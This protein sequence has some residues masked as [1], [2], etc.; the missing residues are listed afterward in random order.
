MSKYPVVYSSVDHIVS[1][2]YI[3]CQVIPCRICCVG[4]DP[5]YVLE[6]SHQRL[7]ICAELVVGLAGTRFN[8]MPFAVCKGKDKLDLDVLEREIHT[9][10]RLHRLKKSPLKNFALIT[11]QGIALVVNSSLLDGACMIVLTR[12]NMT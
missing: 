1:Q 4:V 5:P 11:L 7:K 6:G 8:P 2:E 3:K 9:F 12:S 10:I